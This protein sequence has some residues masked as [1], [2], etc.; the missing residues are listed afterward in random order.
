[1]AARKPK[2]SK[3]ADA[4]AGAGK[5]APAAKKSGSRSGAPARKRAAKSAAD[6]GAPRA[7]A[8]Q[9]RHPLLKTLYAEHRH[10]ASVMQLFAEQLAA[11]E[12]GQPADSHVVYETMDYMVTWPDRYHHPREDLIYSRAAE[13]D[14]GLADS[15]DTLQRDHDST[16][17]AG[18]EVLEDIE[19]WR[20]G[21]VSAARLVKNGRAYIEHMYSHMNSEEELV[22]PQIESTLGAQDWR[23]LAEDDH[24][25]PVSDPVFGYRVQREYRNLARKLRRNIRRGVERGTLVEWL[26]V[27][28]LMESL[29]VLTMARESVRDSAS[30]HLRAAWDD[31][32][33]LFRESALTAPWRCAENNVRLGRRLLQE[34]AEISRDALDD[35]S[36][37]NRER[38]ARIDLMED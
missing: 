5:A 14:A 4:A 35:L 28:A 29:D 19:G 37:V 1:M 16:A 13:L 27:E 22:F 33:A 38:K 31:G 25:R 6:K 15:V 9:V 8:A 17:E 12:A 36:R 3:R 24:L 30:D 34:V 10:I 26:S 21:D 23:E 11:I 32:V 20:D 18:R 2:T 7:E